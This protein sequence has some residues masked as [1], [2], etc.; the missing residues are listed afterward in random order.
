MHILEISGSNTLMSSEAAFHMETTPTYTLIYRGS[1][2]STC[3]MLIFFSFYN[4]PVRYIEYAS[5]IHSGL[6]LV[7]CNKCDIQSV[8]LS[9]GCELRG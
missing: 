5:F 1:S 2:L 4:L 7:S 8:A 6:L 3:L 9:F